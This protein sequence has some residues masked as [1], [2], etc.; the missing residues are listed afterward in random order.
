MGHATWP[1][2]SLARSVRAPRP[3]LFLVV[4]TKSRTKKLITT[5]VMLFQN[6]IV[7]A[8]FRRKDKNASHNQGVSDPVPAAAQHGAG[9]HRRNRSQQRN[10]IRNSSRSWK[11]FLKWRCN[12]HLVLSR[13]RPRPGK[14]SSM[15]QMQRFSVSKKQS[16]VCLVFLE[17]VLVRNCAAG[18]PACANLF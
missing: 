14:L 2:Y 6:K 9:R 17:G 11:N 10:W 8:V 13:R 5:K 4:G 1:V 18:P 3:F 15:F 7:C 12:Y 16:S